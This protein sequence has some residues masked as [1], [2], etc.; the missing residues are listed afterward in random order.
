MKANPFK[1]RREELDLTQQQIA[2]AFTPRL[3]AATVSMWER[4]INTPRRSLIDDLCRI[5]RQPREWVEAACA[6]VRRL[7]GATLARAARRRMGRSIMRSEAGFVGAG[8]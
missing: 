7:R 1:R 2:D 6:Y 3:T 4:G 8:K 5:Y